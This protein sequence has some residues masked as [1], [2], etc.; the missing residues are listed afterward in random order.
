MIP[1]AAAEM[2]AATI[3]TIFAQPDAAAVRTQLD[4]VAVMLGT[5]SPKVEHMLIEANAELTA[6]A[7][8]PHQHWKKIQ[9]TNPLERLNREVKQRSDVVQVFPNT[10]AV[11]RLV[12]AVLFELHD[13]WIAFPAAT[14]PK[15]PW[16]RSTARA[17]PKPNSPPHIKTRT[18]PLHH[19]GGRDPPSA[20]RLGRNPNEH[21][22]NPASK[23]GSSTIFTAA[24]TIRSRT[25]G[26]DN[27]RPASPPGFGINTR[28]AGSGRYHPSRSPPANP[29]S[30]RATPYCST[31]AR[32][33]R[34]MPGAP[35]SARTA[36]HAR[37]RTS[38]R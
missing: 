12:T 25:A 27:G 8:F 5:Q 32:V 3:R 2:V 7:D 23:T 9:S 21:S 30:S 22:A 4:Q 14:Y 31:S 28:R 24:C 19:S 10:D 16:K 17:N 13:E 18:Q 35:S 6:F 33:A 38:L 11:L 37:C 29:S 1:K 34:S 15:A 36:T 26:I 20:E